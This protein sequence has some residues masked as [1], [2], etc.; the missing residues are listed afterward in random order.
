MPVAISAFA[1]LTLL[2]SMVSY[3]DDK[4][5]T[6]DQITLSAAAKTE[7]ENDLISAQLYAQREGTEL[8]LLA[9]AVNQTISKAVDLV[10][11]HGD[12]AVQTMNYHTSPT[13]HKGVVTGWRV[14]QSIKIKS[15]DATQISQLLSQL[16]QTLALESIQ[17]SI[18]TQTRNRVEEELISKAIE[19][20]RQRAN[21]I[22]QQMNRSDYRLVEM[23]IHTPGQNVSP[24]LM[25]ANT[26]ALEQ[27]VAPP[28][29]ETGSQTLR[30]EV[31]GRIELAVGH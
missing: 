13:Y 15:K 23:N 24:V 6:Y 19:L 29:L 17:Y 22:T 27:S 7:V 31:S 3:A 4:D 25:R 9:D 5:R 26:M 1:C 2:I 20:F 16:Q 10:K 30:V 28:S 8:P 12:F 11:S 18:S 21:K 14:R